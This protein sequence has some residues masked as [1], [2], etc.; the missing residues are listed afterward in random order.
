M[1]AGRSMEYGRRD[2]IFGAPQHPYTWGLLESMPTVER[3]MEALVP[4][5]GSP[6][7]AAQPAVRLPLPSALPATASSRCDQERAAPRADAR[8]PSRRVLPRR[9][10][11]SARVGAARE[12]LGVGELR[13][14]SGV[15]EPAQRRAGTSRSSSSSI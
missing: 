2:E 4:I 5:E 12:Q 9:R 3:R 13:K 8:R 1:Y 11:G 15:H 14:R 10:S 7:V 6:A